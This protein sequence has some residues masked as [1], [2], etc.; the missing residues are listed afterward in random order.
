MLSCSAL[1]QNNAP[2]SSSDEVIEAMLRLANTGTSD[3]AYDLTCGDGRV[4]VVAAK[5]L[6]AHGVCIE[7]DANRMKLAKENIE[8][9]GV[10]SMITF[11]EEDPLKTDIK[12]AS[13]VVFTGKINQVVRKKLLH[14]LTVG[15]RIVST[16]ADLGDWKPEKS[17]M[18]SGQPIYEWIMKTEMIPED[19]PK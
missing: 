10:T 5:K 6:G 4:M 13:V 1:S 17:G 8:K 3:V 9:A 12:G 2:A 16:I 15:T 18:V 14:E 7:P 11:R 19:T